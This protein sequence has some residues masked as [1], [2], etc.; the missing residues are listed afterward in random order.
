ML[1]LNC[2]RR[3][4]AA[5]RPPRAGCWEGS[6]FSGITHLRGKTL[7]IVGV[8]NI[9]PRVAGLACAFGMRV[10]GYDPYV[11]ADELER[12]GVE[13]VGRLDELLPQVDILTCHTPLTAETRHMVNER[14]IGLMKRGAVFINT[15]RG[16]VQDE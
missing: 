8:G 6:R 15:S 12:R 11:P 3:M 13:P 7:G 14:M 4:P 16:P 1:M 9:G 2:A 5:T 10:L